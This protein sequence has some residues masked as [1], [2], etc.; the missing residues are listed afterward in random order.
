[1][2]VMRRRSS[3]LYIQS[4]ISSSNKYCCEHFL[5]L[6]KNN[7]H[8]KVKHHVN[9]SR[10]CFQCPG[11][12]GFGQLYMNKANAESTAR[13]YTSQSIFILLKIACVTFYIRSSSSIAHFSPLGKCKAVFRGKAVPNFR[14]LYLFKDCMR[15]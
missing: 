2:T 4:Y 1:M 7:G 6:F 14:P 5:A 12:I 3:H 13:R 8:E 15:S 11:E 9:T 10:L